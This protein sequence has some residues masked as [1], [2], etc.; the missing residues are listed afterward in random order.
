M[1]SNNNFNERCYE[2]LKLIPEGKVTTY[3]EIA[4]A[5]NTKAWRAVGTAMAKNK[6]LYIIPCHRVVRSDGTIGQY[7][8]GSSKKA[9]LLIKEGVLVANGKVKNLNKFIHKFST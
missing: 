6:N 7:A 5:L 3:R 9:E 4:K 2:L 1:N 8:L